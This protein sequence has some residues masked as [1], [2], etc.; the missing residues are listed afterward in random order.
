MN[1]RENAM[2]PTTHD[3][4]NQPPPLV[5]INL[6]DLDVVLKEALCREGEEWVKDKAHKFGEIIGSQHCINLAFEANRHLP[7]LHAF[8]RYGHRIDEVHYHPA[9]HELMKL[10]IENEIHSI[11][12]NSEKGGHV[13]HTRLHNFIVC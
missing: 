1:D 13:A 8:D 9:Y 5:N 2:K 6:Y 10:A 4:V 7:E 11:A 3:V 12:W